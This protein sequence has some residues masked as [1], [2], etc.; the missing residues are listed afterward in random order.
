M[1]TG[2]EDVIEVWGAYRRPRRSRAFLV[3][4]ALLACGAIGKVVID[5]V[6]WRD[7][8]SA[9]RDALTTPGYGPDDLR[10][11]VVVLQRNIRASIAVLRSAEANGGEIGKQA[12]NALASC[13]R[14]FDEPFEDLPKPR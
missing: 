13:R 8:S 5:A 6:H 2:N 7:A 12:A 14:A 4:V 11:A 1:D 3:V 9:A 10:A